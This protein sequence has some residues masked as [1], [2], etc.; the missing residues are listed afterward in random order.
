MP[1]HAGNIWSSFPRHRGM[2][3]SA[4][5]LIISVPEEERHRLQRLDSRSGKFYSVNFDLFDMR[6][7]PSQHTLASNG[8]QQPNVSLSS[9][10]KYHMPPAC[11]TDR[12]YTVTAT[13]GSSKL[14]IVWAET[15]RTPGRYTAHI[16]I[17]GPEITSLLLTVTTEHGLYSED[18]V[19]VA[20]ATTFYVWI[21][22]FL[23]LPVVLLC[24]LS[25]GRV[26]VLSQ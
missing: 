17:N 6:C 18:T 12:T 13:K 26:P 7:S 11:S 10:A 8:R 25:L 22:Y 20:V 24:I 2:S 9:A 19:A 5:D 14:E 16:P 4:G 23:L 21:K 3:F 15:F 1:R